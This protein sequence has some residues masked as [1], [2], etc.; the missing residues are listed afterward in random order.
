MKIVRVH[1][2]SLIVCRLTAADF[3]RHDRNVDSPVFSCAIQVCREVICNKDTSR[4]INS[5]SSNCHFCY[6]RTRFK[7]MPYIHS[8][9]Y[10]VQ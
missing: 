7:N 10:T 9:C 3:C 6:E 5:Y 2:A 8:V 1:L 4:K